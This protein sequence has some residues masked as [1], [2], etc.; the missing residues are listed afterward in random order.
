MGTKDAV[1]TNYIKSWQDQ[2][3]DY[4]MPDD[5]RAVIVGSNGSDNIGAAIASHFRSTKA[6]EEVAERDI[7][8]LNLTVP[9]MVSEFPWIQYDTVVLANGQTSLNWIEDQSYDSI[10]SV[11]ENKLMGSM[12]AVHEFVAQ[13]LDEEFTKNIILI[14]SMAAG[15]VLNGS[16]VYC[17]S[18]AGLQH[19]ARCVAW[20]L[21]PKGYRVFLLNPS[22]TE[23]TPMTE[24]TIKGLMAY[25][26]LNR[27][28]A[29]S[30]W[31]ATRA[32]PRWLQAG[33]IAS[34]AHW[35]VTTPEAEWLSGVPLNL[36]GGLR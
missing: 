32:L 15:A 12:Y 1:S 35:L 18:C 25:R 23:G 8:T 14:G 7:D 5:R 3:R 22:N 16:S 27:I 26:G 9:E 21:A 2:T 6:F 31:G 28:D 10:K 4:M 20:E 13:T 29:E 24:E 11:L 17:A 33:D 30:Y 34:I 36:G 19:F